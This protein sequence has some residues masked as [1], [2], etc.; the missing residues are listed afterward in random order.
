MAGEID[1]PPAEPTPHSIAHHRVCPTFEWWYMGRKRAIVLAA[2]VTNDGAACAA[3]DP[4]RMTDVYEQRQHFYV[5]CLAGGALP[6]FTIG[7]QARFDQAL[8]DAWHGL[9]PEGLLSEAA[10]EKFESMADLVA[11]TNVL[12][13]A[14]GR[15]H[16]RGLRRVDGRVRLRP[17]HLWHQAAATALRFAQRGSP[18]RGFRAPSSARAPPRAA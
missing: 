17:L 14:S 12:A 11:A 1:G 18:R 9:G 16:P 2:R 6:R 5:K 3:S 7:D 10:R 8:C 4:D 15:G 13:R